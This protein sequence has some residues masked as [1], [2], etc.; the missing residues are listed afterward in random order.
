MALQ[1]IASVLCEAISMVVSQKPRLLRRPPLHSGLPAMTLEGRLFRH[2]RS[3][4][5]ALIRRTL[6]V[7]RDK[8]SLDGQIR[9]KF[10]E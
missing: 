8:R 5:P 2:V 3:A 9:S 6:G 10:L 7:R 1:V 4:E